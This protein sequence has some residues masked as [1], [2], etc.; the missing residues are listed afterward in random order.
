M[1]NFA[2][3]AARFLQ[4]IE[5]L[6][7][8]SFVLQHPSNL[9]YLFNF[10]GP[11]TALWADGQATLLVDSRYAEQAFEQAINCRPRLFQGTPE[12]GLREAL[13]PLP[14]KTRIGIEADSASWASVLKMA[15][16]NLDVELVPTYDVVEELRMIKEVSEIQLLQEACSLACQALRIWLDHFKSGL[17]EVEAAGHGVHLVYVCGSH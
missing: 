14:G 7:L 4:S 6:Q 1:H 12:E 3:R 5:R 15:S 16:W 9:A 8:D 13:S 17:P 2:E 10:R 11:G